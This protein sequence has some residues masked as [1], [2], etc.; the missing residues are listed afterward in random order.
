MT[1]TAIAKQYPSASSEV[2]GRPLAALLA[3]DGARV[4]SVDINSIQVRIHKFDRF[5]CILIL[6]SRNTPSGPKS[7]PTR[8]NQ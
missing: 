4:V 8:Q 1:G 2:V 3:N 7:R 6:L 5:L